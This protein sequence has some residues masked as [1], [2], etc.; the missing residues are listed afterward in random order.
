MPTE[1]E[2]HRLKRQAKWEG[3]VFYASIAFILALGIALIIVNSP[4]AKWPAWI[5]V[6]ILTIFGLSVAFGWIQLD[7]PRKWSDTLRAIDR[8]EGRLEERKKSKD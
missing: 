3:R 6:A 5:M 2:L 1:K 8:M 4:S 7:P